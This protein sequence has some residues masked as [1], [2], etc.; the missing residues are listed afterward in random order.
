MTDF[1]IHTQNTAPAA[2]KPLLG[3]AE[4]AYGFV[5]G[6]LGVLAEAP[7]ALDAY[8]ILGSLFSETSLTTTSSTWCGSPSTTRMIV[9]IVC[10]RT[11]VSRN[12]TQCRTT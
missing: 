1:T 3:K 8:Q 10:P 4:K 5:P 7:K 12:E 11:P 6:L 2:S 9:A